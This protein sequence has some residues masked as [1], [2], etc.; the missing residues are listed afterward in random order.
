M[1]SPWRAVQAEQAANGKPL[2]GTRV[3]HVG[4]T[5]GISDC[6]IQENKAES[7]R[8]GGLL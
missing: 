5:A 2:K 8:H 3:Q 4:R 6:W 7:V 1:G